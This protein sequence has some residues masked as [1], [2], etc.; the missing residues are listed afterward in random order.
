MST[1][2]RATIQTESAQAEESFAMDRYLVAASRWISIRASTAW[3]AFGMGLVALAAATAARAEVPGGQVYVGAGGAI[4]AAS[5]G[6]RSGA[7]FLELNYEQPRSFFTLRLTE[8][9]ARADTGLIFLFA[10]LSGHYVF[11]DSPW[12]PYLGGGVAWQQQWVNT[13][14]DCADGGTG[15]FTGDYSGPALSAEAGF[16][17]WRNLRFGRAAAFGQLLVPLFS[18]HDSGNHPGGDGAHLL[19]LAGARVS[20]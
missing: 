17:F 19:F 4:S 18:V 13:K 15:C 10:S 9:N 14:L 2:P 3:L 8:G 12:T 5:E 16:L 1:V 20:L 11:L 6:R 7:L